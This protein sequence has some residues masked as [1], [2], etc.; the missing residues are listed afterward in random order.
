MKKYLMTLMLALLAL[1]LFSQQTHAGLPELIPYRI[2]DKWGYSDS[3]GEVKWPCIY[4]TV[5]FFVRD[6]AHVKE[7]GIWKLF[8][9]EGNTILDSVEAIRGSR[10]IQ[11]IWPEDFAR[12]YRY[13]YKLNRY[14]SPIPPQV[15]GYSHAFHL[16]SHFFALYN[17]EKYALATQEGKLLTEP[18]YVSLHYRSPFFIASK[19]DGELI[20]VVIDTFG[21]EICHLPE[22]IRELEALGKY[23]F[24]TW[25]KKRKGTPKGKSRVVHLDGRIIEIPKKHNEA[26]KFSPRWPPDI[27][28]EPIPGFLKVKIWK[29]PEEEYDAV[30]EYLLFDSLGNQVF[31]RRFNGI[32]Q[33][34]PNVLAVCDIDQAF[35][36]QLHDL[37]GNPLGIS[38]FS[39]EGILAENRESPLRPWVKVG[40]FQSKWVHVYNGETLL[41]RRRV[42]KRES[43]TIQEGKCFHLNLSDLDIFLQIG[44]HLTSHSFL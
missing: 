44:F 36:W 33:I 43:L 31:D 24:L 22:G 21:N 26:I 41:L 10:E 15:T 29:R 19:T 18:I 2:G 23:F 28:E 34:A 7:Q 27:N 5:T 38:I 4:D 30:W 20:E 14:N 11:F 8:D 12:H 40:K 32:K 9:K 13:R 42:R 39:A 16:S 37:K 1:P 3:L 17:G 35:V 6:Y 25:N